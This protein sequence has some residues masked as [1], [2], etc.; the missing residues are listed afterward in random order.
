MR[1]SLIG[2]LRKHCSYTSV[3]LTLILCIL[4]GSRWRR[5]TGSDG[6]EFAGNCRDG[7]AGPRSAFLG[8]EEPDQK[9]TSANNRE[10]ERLPNI[11]E[12]S[13]KD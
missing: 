1:V 3:I 9:R 4:K 7:G 13:L 12:L 8:W 11:T 5:N 10:Q 6:Y 2:S